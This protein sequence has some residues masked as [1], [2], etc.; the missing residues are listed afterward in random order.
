MCGLVGVAGTLN[1]DIIKAFYQLLVI[2]QLRGQHSTGVAHV[3]SYNN[4]VSVMKVVGGPEQL[5]EMTSFEKM[6]RVN[7][8]VLIGHNRYATSGKIT[9]NNAHPFDFDNVVGAHNGSL[10]AYARLPGFGKYDVDSQVLYDAIDQWGIEDTLPK[11]GGAYCLT[12]FDKGDQS[13]NFIR[14]TERPL[15]IAEVNKGAAIVW[16]SEEGMLDW[17]LH[18]NNITAEEIYSLSPDVLVTVSLKTGGKLIAQTKALKGGT[19]ISTSVVPFRGTHGYQQTGTQTSQ[20]TTTTTSSTGTAN[21]ALVGSDGREKP[22]MEAAKEKGSLFRLGLEGVT[23]HGAPFYECTKAGSEKKYRLYTNQNNSYTA[24]LKSGLEIIA[25]TNGMEYVGNSCVYRIL[26][27]SVKVVVGEV[28]EVVLSSE[29]VD[30]DGVI[31][32][33]AVN[34]P[35][36]GVYFEDSQGRYMARKEWVKR[37]G[38]CAY[39]S[40]D[41]DPTEQW[42][43]IHDE[44]LCQDCSLNPIIADALTS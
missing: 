40:G 23:S 27:S 6:M 38:N 8:K 17:I 44:I 15:Y 37:Y 13:M 32:A 18:R 19:E 14:N 42:K 11:V 24:G 30:D 22:D 10:R 31:L 25:D 39:C 9:K 26:A 29:T 36:D 12:Y 34:E 41:V 3:S 28:V 20:A 16:A 43:F 4:D 33:K 2:D 5:L 35:E 21:G 7:P 1:Q